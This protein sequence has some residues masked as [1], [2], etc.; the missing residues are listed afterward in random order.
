ML[1]RLLLTV[2]LGALA[3]PV[4][5][6]PSIQTSQSSPPAYVSVVDGVATIERDNRVESNPL[7]MP[8]VSGDRLRT[9]EGRMEI[10][11]ADGRTLDLDARTIVDVQSDTRLRVMD[12]RIR[13][14][15]APAPVVAWRID[16][17]AGSAR[18]LEPGEYRLALVA[19]PREAQG[20]VQLEF[21]VVL[22]SGEIFTDYGKTTVNAGERA[23]ASAD[24]LPSEPY[25]FNSA[26]GD[27][28]DR[29]PAVP[30]PLST[31]SSSDYLP[32]DL[33]SYTSTF[34]AYG[35]W[36]YLPSY[37][38]VWC[39]RVSADWRPYAFGRWMT[40]PRYGL[41]WVGS[42][43]FAWPTH[44]YGRWGMVSGRW[45]WM[46]ASNWAPA[47][48]TWS[49]AGDSVSWAPLAPNSRA[50]SP[51]SRTVVSRA[52][53]D[54]HTIVPD[55][56]PIDQTRTAPIDHTRMG[57]TDQPRGQTRS[58]LRTAS[59]PRAVAAP[60]APQPVVTPTRTL[61]P[62]NPTPRSQVRPAGSPSPASLSWRTQPPAATQ[63]HVAEPA[64][65][66]APAPPQGQPA[67]AAGQ[68]PAAQP[69]SAKSSGRGEGA[70]PSK[71]TPAKPEGQRGHQTEGQRGQPP[72]PAHA[73]PR[74][75]G[76]V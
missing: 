4:S 20:D 50:A 10:R 34:D 51:A 61:P 73:A 29:W 57:S 75:R 55:I 16:S 41:T 22:G 1:R 13:V 49:S 27:D 28:F 15:V 74:G 58:V 7:N 70:G 18:P 65:L 35:D 45:F 44:H 40:Y 19:G 31:D 56:H 14:K 9:T 52:D 66:A 5:G 54:R 30:A 36:L 21:A 42:E 6:Q 63:P 11:F 76:S 71:A 43:P 3:V 25:P 64:P 60:A 39:P 62:R 24:L 26:L 47:H 23:Y 38:R 53:F 68:Q 72:Q 2:A 33:Q 48:V 12:G 59:A 46:P 69:P 17:P 67:A 8:L 32:S 37:G